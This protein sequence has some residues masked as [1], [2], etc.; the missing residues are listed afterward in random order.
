MKESP[1]LKEL[2]ERFS[3]L[4][5]HEDL[6]VNSQWLN[7]RESESFPLVDRLEIYRYAYKAR[8]EE[9]LEEDYPKVRKLV[10]KR[11]FSKIFRSFLNQYPSTYNS[12]AEV[13]QNFS[14]FLSEEGETLLSEVAR[15][16]WTKI[17][18][19]LTE[20]PQASNLGELG[21]VA[22]EDFEHLIFLLVPSAHLFNSIANIQV[23][24]PILGSDSY[25]VLYRRH[26]KV[27]VTKL[28]KPQF[29]LLGKLQAGS[30]L[31][32]LADWMRDQKI[33]EKQTTL[34]F[35][36]WVEQG[37]IYRFLAPISH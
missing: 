5:S 21:Q 10:G 20:D 8:I 30:S 31:G 24:S 25:L 1:H 26:G 6:P 18:V 33:T 12:L 9:S 13:S 22:A 34:W 4:L 28:A 27:V 7:L 32:S 19:F 15:F 29:Q 14:R 3:H 11:R 17:L 16:E 35:Q 2:Q 23:Q 36:Q 37:I